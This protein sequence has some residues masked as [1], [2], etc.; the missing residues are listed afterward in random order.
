MLRRY[1]LALTRN[2]RDLY[3]RQI[4][5]AVLVMILFMAS[6][7][8]THRFGLSIGYSLSLYVLVTVVMKVFD[9]SKHVFFE[10]TDNNLIISGDIF[11]KTVELS[12]LDLFSMRKVDLSQKGPESLKWKLCGTGIPGY[13]SGL[14]S[15]RNGTV[16]CVFLS[17][18]TQVV[19]IPSLKGESLLL[20]LEDAE[21]FMLL[22]RSNRALK[23]APKIA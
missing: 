23:Y 20:S 4:I 22:L 14:F 8:T 12:S 6:Y 9:R 21:T 13:A 15:L 1:P 10:I 2:A 5:A 17:D 19:Y 7:L 16:A 11:G 3:Y 18:L